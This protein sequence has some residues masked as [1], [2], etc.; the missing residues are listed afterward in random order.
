[1]KESGNAAL[2]PDWL[3]SKRDKILPY[4]EVTALQMAIRGF[5]RERDGNNK[6]GTVLYQ[7]WGPINL[8]LNTLGLTGGGNR[9]LIK[10]AK[11]QDSWQNHILYSRTALSIDEPSCLDH[12]LRGLLTRGCDKDNIAA[13]P[14]KRPLKA[15]PSDR[16][17]GVIRRGGHRYGVNTA[18]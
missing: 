13:G 2:S 9:R 6:E 7:S 16:I 10:R 1:M 8:E 15:P 17:T 3:L 4:C 11:D 5:W 18:A 12:S 14:L